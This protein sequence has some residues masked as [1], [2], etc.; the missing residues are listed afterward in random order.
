MIDAYTFY[1]FVVDILSLTVPAVLTLGV[2]THA[3]VILCLV[4]FEMVLFTLTIIL[5]YPRPLPTE[6]EGIMKIVPFVYCILMQ[7]A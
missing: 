7:V 4:A 2:I 1:G 6:I 5:S 3:Y